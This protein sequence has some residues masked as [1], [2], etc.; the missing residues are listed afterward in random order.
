M[1]ANTGQLLTGVDHL[2]QSI[3]NILSTPIGSRV[4]RR[5][6]GSLLFHMV[7][8]PANPA[9][10]MR[11]IAASADALVRW[12]PRLNLQRLTTSI[13]SNGKAAITVYGEDRESGERVLF[14][15]VP[16]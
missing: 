11:L 15:G 9:G 7:D 4:M 10:R 6:Y 14:E 2:R 13:E 8:Q 3:G 12:E 16:L 5:D 1:S